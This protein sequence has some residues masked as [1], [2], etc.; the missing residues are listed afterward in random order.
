MGFD[1]HFESL[2]QGETR[3]YEFLTFGDYGQHIGIKGMQKLVNRVIKCFMTP[4]GSDISDPEYGTNLIQAFQGNIEPTALS[5]LATMAVR[6]TELK[7]RE[8]D[9]Q[10]SSPTDERLSGIEIKNIVVDPDGTGVVIYI[11][12][13]NVA[14]ARALSAIP[15]ELD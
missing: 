2:P 6:D 11:I 15:L 5:E 1:I 10:K 14:G 7:I 13:R 8:Y 4:K 12:V 9:A 3:G